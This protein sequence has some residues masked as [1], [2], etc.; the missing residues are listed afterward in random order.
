MKNLSVVFLFLLTSISL[1]A[2]GSEIGVIETF[3]GETIRLYK[4]PSSRK[5]NFSKLRVGCD[6]TIQT[7]KFY[8][9]NNKGKVEKMAEKY[10]KKLVLNKGAN[11][12]RDYERSSSLG[13]GSTR[14]ISLESGLEHDTEM[15]ALPVG[16]RGKRLV[17]Q[18]ILAR[19]KKYT[20][21]MYTSDSGGAHI[22]ICSVKDRKFIDHE[23]YLYVRKSKGF[24]EFYQKLKTYFKNCDKL[25]ELLEKNEKTNASISKRNQKIPP[26][27]GISYIN[28]E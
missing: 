14:G 17:L 25:I 20:L 6:C 12:C 19:N 24:I 22:T 18:T 5:V 11:Y 26:L 2:T 28:C 23:G 4:H 10:I 7:S 21:S 3:K 9:I 27:E 8:F 13:S 16:S 15:R 1:L